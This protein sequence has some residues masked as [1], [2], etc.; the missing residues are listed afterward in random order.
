MTT[1]RPFGTISS[2]DASATSTTPERASANQ[3]TA[4]VTRTFTRSPGRTVAR[5]LSDVPTSLKRTPVA[6]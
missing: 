1:G 3:L 5:T 2:V 6:R 4:G